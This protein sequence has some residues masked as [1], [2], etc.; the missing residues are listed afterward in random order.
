MQLYMLLKSSLYSRNSCSLLSPCISVFKQHA[1]IVSWNCRTTSHQQFMFPN[2]LLF[3]FFHRMLCNFFVHS[4]LNEFVGKLN[5]LFLYQCFAHA[6]QLAAKKSNSRFY[7][8][9][10]W[11]S[12]SRE[13]SWIVEK[14]RDLIVAYFSVPNSELKFNSVPWITQL[15]VPLS[16]IVLCALASRLASRQRV[17]AM[18]S[19]FL[20]LEERTWATFLVVPF[21]L[22][23]WSFSLLVFSVDVVS[24]FV[25]G[26][27]KSGISLA[28]ST[29][30]HDAGVSSGAG[31]TCCDATS[32]TSISNSKAC[33]G[34][35]VFSLFCL[36]QWPQLFSLSNTILDMPSFYMSKTWKGSSIS[37]FDVNL[38]VILSL[39]S[40]I[41]TSKWKQIT[42]CW[43]N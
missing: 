8:I 2:L 11:W 23:P 25:I 3:L 31:V 27:E 43:I 10:W 38:N 1:N 9:E 14:M 29:V 33:H 40:S 15:Y 17:A 39:P 6:C 12:L 16:T 37:I 20:I 36:L 21:F 13:I 4:S 19:A 32:G 22:P 28:N 30:C 5:N 35:G 42:V 24:S 18:V 41:S 26:D 7:Q 34:A